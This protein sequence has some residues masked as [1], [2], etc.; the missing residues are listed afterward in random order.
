MAR[1]DCDQ[2]AHNVFL[3]KLIQNCSVEKI[4]PIN[5]VNFQK[6]PKVR[7]HPIGKKSPN[8]VT[9]IGSEVCARQRFNERMYFKTKALKH[10]SRFYKP[11]NGT[12]N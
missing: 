11:Q 8:L 1:W 7:K 2:I 10:G 5:F 3:S 9:L 6:V 4:S 12:G